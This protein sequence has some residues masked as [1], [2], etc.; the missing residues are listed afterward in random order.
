LKFL[1]RT[2]ILNRISISILQLFG[3]ILKV[4]FFV[5]FKLFPNQRFLIPKYTKPIWKTKNNPTIPKK[6]WQTNYTNK[7]TFPVYFNYLWNRLM[8]PTFEYHYWIDNDRVS[9]INENFSSE[10][11]DAFNKIQIGAAQADYW[12]I[13]VLLKYGGIYLDNDAAFTF[14][15]QTFLSSKDEEL[16]I[17]VKSNE[18]T[19]YFLASK[20]NHPIFSAIA[21]QIKINIDENKLTCVYN[22]TGPRVVDLIVK[23]LQLNIQQHRFVCKQGIFMRK[24]MQYPDNLKN[25]WTIEQ[26]NKSILK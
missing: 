21:H 26:K 8:A 20:P 23:D 4:V 17:K 3:N 5:H 12:R 24:S 2:P 25:C 13:L 6:I 10:I 19:N 11:F 1:R 7:V 15:P 9:F 18:I 22:M 14:P 16:F